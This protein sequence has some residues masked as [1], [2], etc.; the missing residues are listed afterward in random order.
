MNDIK[1]AITL[2][3]VLSALYDHDVID[4]MPGEPPYIQLS[5]D[6]FRTL[7]PYIIPDEKKYLVTYLDGVKIL[8]V[9]HV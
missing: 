9:A 6:K 3:P 4:I 2:I 1:L 8:A 5:E 7:F